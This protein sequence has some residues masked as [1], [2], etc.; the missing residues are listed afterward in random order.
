M[1]VHAGLNWTELR[2]WLIRP[3]PISI[4]CNNRRIGVRAPLLSPP[5]AA[6]G[7]GG[8]AGGVGKRWG[9]QAGILRDFGF[10]GGGSARRSQH[11]H[12]LYGRGLI[13]ADEA[14]PTQGVGTIV[15]G[16]DQDVVIGRQA[17]VP[18]QVSVAFGGGFWSGDWRV[19]GGESQE[20]PGAVLVIGS[21]PF[22]V[23]IFFI[24]GLDFGG[25]T[26]LCPCFERPARGVGSQRR[27]H[28][29]EKTALL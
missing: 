23:M 21:V 16:A 22:V 2:A 10:D 24:A 28:G 5:A 8:E 17:N 29:E 18:G 27:Y 9:F 4:F 26:Q 25:E 7:L 11:Q 12:S 13:S 15:A 3:Q 1:S 19:E 20:L 14:M 6:G